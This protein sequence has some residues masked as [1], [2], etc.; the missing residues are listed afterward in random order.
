MSA[1][2]VAEAKLQIEILDL[3]DEISYLKTEH[4]FAID[5]NQEINSEL[6]NIKKKFEAGKR[7]ALEEQQSKNF[8]ELLNLRKDLHQKAVKFYISNV[9]AELKSAGV[10]QSKI[11]KFTGKREEIEEKLG[12]IFKINQLR[13]PIK[14][15]RKRHRESLAEKSWKYFEERK[16]ERKAERKRKNEDIYWESRDYRRA[17]RVKRLKLEK[18]IEDEEGEQRKND[19]SIFF[20]PES[21]QSPIQYRIETDCE[22]EVDIEHFEK[23]G[24]CPTAEPKSETEEIEDYKRRLDEYVQQQFEIHEEYQR[25][26][27]EEERKREEDEYYFEPESPQSP[28]QYRI[29][30]DCEVEIDIPRYGDDQAEHQDGDEFRVLDPFQGLD[31]SDNYKLIHYN[32]VSSLANTDDES[33]EVV[34]V[35]N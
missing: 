10:E 3:K 24:K 9:V 35:D 6:A 19:E 22:V 26:A 14:S 32:M 2:N 25:E 29:E 8:N 1:E 31:F 12:K 5:E 27:D 34:V 30:T 7:T 13:V 21:P 4:R 20:E 17:N 23:P 28:I 18:F 16:A 15:C 33:E 11:D